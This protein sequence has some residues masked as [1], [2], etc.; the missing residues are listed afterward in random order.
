MSVLLEHSAATAALQP[1]GGRPGYGRA[2]RK[3]QPPGQQKTTTGPGR[4][5]APVA[6]PGATAPEAGAER[7]FW[8]QHHD[9][10]APFKTGV[11]LDLGDLFG[12]AFEAIEQP[13][14]E[15]LV[16]HFA[17]AE[18]QRHLDLVAFPEEA[19]H[20]AHLH[21]VIVIVDHRAEFDF[22]DFDDLLLLARFRLL[23]LL[24]KFVLAKIEQLADRRLGVRRNLDEVEAGLLRQRQCV[25]NRNCA[26]VG[27]VPI[28]QMNLAFADVIID[29]R[30]VFRD[31][32]RGSHRATNG[33]LLLLLLHIPQRRPSF[34]TAP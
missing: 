24:L 30:T 1:G 9:H 4:K 12:I 16:R 8:R 34:R 23:F 15:F 17:A 21:I 2:A 32:W 11:H 25:G 27:T 19:N 33:Y 14:A 26:A 6:M 18:A 5:S 29:A 31:G 7:L 13:D 28:D 10:L 22:L 20:R 3:W